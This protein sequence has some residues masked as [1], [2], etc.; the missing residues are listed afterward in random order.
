[1]ISLTLSST[2]R[3]NHDEIIQRWLENIHGQTAEDYE[4]VLRTP[5]GHAVATNLLNYAVELMGAEEYQESELL[6]RARDA[7]RDASFRRAAVG[8]CLPDIIT[9]AMALRSAMQETLLN[10]VTPGDS[11]DEQT[12]VEGLLAINRLGD[13]IVSGEIAGYFAY[14]EYTDKEENRRNHMV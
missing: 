6:H 14:H 12:I 9:T 7:A 5:M 13:A 11:V 1:M 4:Q 3:E 8:F 2:L 10:H